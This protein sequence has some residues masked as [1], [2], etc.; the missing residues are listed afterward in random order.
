MSATTQTNDHPKFVRRLVHWWRDWIRRRAAAAEV[1]RCGPAGMER[2][3]QDLAV[4]QAELRI[5]AG[6]WPARVDSIYRRNCSGLWAESIHPSVSRF[7]LE[8]GQ[9]EDVVSD[10]KTLQSPSPA[11]DNK[12]N[13][14]RKS[15]AGRMAALRAGR[16]CIAAR[17]AL[18]NC[19]VR[20]QSCSCT[21]IAGGAARLDICPCAL[22][23][24][25]CH[26]QEQREPARDRAALPHLASQISDRKFVSAFDRRDRC[27]PSYDAAV[28]VGG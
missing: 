27:R 12:S 7:W 6:K 1:D 25:S 9:V 28:S 11:A 10:L 14:S 8:A 2:L 22:R 24:M 4:G 18:R 20:E 16:N 26:R 21:A 13:G 3:T 23:A 15:R 19:V 17:R 5:L